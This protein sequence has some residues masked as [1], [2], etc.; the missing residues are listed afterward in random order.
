MQRKPMQNDQRLDD[1]NPDD[2][3]IDDET[4][5][6][7]LIEMSEELS[8]VNDKSDSPLAADGDGLT[9]L[10]VDMEEFFRNDNAPMETSTSLISATLQTCYIQP[11]A[12]SGQRSDS[13]GKR[14]RD[15]A[16]NEENESSENVIAETPVSV[17]PQ[18]KQ[19]RILSSRPS[20]CY[21]HRYD[22]EFISNNRIRIHFDRFAHTQASTA[23]TILKSRYRTL[24]SK[25]DDKF[26]DM[27]FETLSGIAIISIDS[28]REF[29]DQEV[30]AQLQEL[31]G[32]NRVYR[33]SRYG[34]D[35]A[36]SQVSVHSLFNRNTINS[37]QSAI[38][39]T[40][41]YDF[42]FISN[43]KVRVLFDMT[44]QGRASEDTSNL[45]S[46]YN[47]LKLNFDTLIADMNFETYEGNVYINIK[48]NDRFSAEEI[49]A[50]LQRITGGNRVLSEHV[51][52]NTRS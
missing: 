52:R 13:L 21:T 5:N 36:N 32:G 38:I 43:N 45:R 40:H 25:R 31:T 1:L 9:P 27:K 4:F 6:R 42:E 2:W 16:E 3:Q 17:Q 41:H 22:F 20:K 14:K 49:E 33:E 30:E 35:T 44:V 28:S 7:I 34:N 29:S 51:N 11:L 50:Q 39:Y 37:S 46:R 24:E 48:N 12:P 23:T 19:R 18:T 8:Q 26:V 47:H 10:R 15:D